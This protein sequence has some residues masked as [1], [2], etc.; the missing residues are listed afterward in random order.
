MDQMSR[1]GFLRDVARNGAGIAAIAVAGQM[2][3]PRDASAAGPQRRSRTLLGTITAIHDGLAEVDVQGRRLT[4]MPLHGFP[5]GYVP[6]VGEKVV[7]SDRLGREAD[8]QVQPLVRVTMGTL[9]AEGQVQS[10]ISY[11]RGQPL[12]IDTSTTPVGARLRVWAS[13]N[14]RFTTERIMWSAVTW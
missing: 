4:E 7:L 2:T 12:G 1:R 14:E 9:G 13:N 3:W 5:P 6:E 8:Y 10:E 11:L